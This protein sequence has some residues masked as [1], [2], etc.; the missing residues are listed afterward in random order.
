MRHRQRRLLRLAVP[1]ALL[2][3]VLLVG[4]GKS[5]KSSSPTTTTKTVAPVNQAASV[6]VTEYAFTQPSVT[7]KVG[8]A[9]LWTNEG[10]VDHTVTETAADGIASPEIK[11]GQSYTLTF[12]TPGTYA[13]ICSIHP[14]SMKGTVIVQAAN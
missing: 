10:N 1:F 14:D 4:C 9:V 12:Q 5:S 2:G 6:K 7:V 8:Q 3:A 13:Y 11:P